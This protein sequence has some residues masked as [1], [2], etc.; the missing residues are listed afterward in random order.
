[1]NGN[2]FMEKNPVR[3]INGRIIDY[4]QTSD[5]LASFVFILGMFSRDG[6]CIKR[7]NPWIYK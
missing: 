6:L 2:I 5:M 1:M 4:D 3:S 7:R